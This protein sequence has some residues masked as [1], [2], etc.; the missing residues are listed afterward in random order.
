M[1]CQTCIKSLPSE[2]H[3]FSLVIVLWTKVRKLL[4]EDGMMGKSVWQTKKGVG[5]AAKRME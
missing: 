3:S 4:L 2:Q 1:S 5:G